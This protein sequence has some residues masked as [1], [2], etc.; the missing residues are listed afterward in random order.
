MPLKVSVLNL[1]LYD[2]KMVSSRYGV[3]RLGKV[4]YCVYDE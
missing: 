2:Q 3:G 1:K 4:V